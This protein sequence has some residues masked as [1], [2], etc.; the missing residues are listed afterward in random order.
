[1]I[2]EGTPSKYL[3]GVAALIKKM[4]DANRRCL[5]L[6]SPAMVEGIR[7]YLR[8]TGVNAGLQVERGALILSASHDHLVHGRFDPDKMLE[9]LEKGVRSALRAGFEGLWATGD[10]TWEFGGERNFSKLLE[11]EHKLEKLFERQPAL[12]GLCQ[13]HTATLPREA[14]RDGLMTHEAVSLNE[15]IAR[16]NPH[17]AAAGEE[18]RDARVSALELRGM[19][20]RVRSAAACEAPA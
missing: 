14:V 10:M 19:L 8:A 6:N 18:S 12:S 4:L 3:G 5:Y 9:L 13:Y 1:V 17:Y 2:Y 16:I 11:Y 20:A 15:T 7:T